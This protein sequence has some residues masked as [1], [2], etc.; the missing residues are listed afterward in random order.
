MSD[1]PNKK[2]ADAKLISLN[3]RHEVE[4]WAKRFNISQQELRRVVSVAGHAVRDVEAYLSMT[5]AQQLF[6]KRRIQ[7]VERVGYERGKSKK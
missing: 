2:L 5:A 1:N 3:Q 4:Y 7:Y 6:F